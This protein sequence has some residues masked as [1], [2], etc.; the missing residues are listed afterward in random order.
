MLAIKKQKNVIISLSVIFCIIILVVGIILP[1][2]PFK[3]Q[4]YKNYGRMIKSEKVDIPIPNQS[5]IQVLKYY[6]EP[7]W[8]DFSGTIRIPIY[9]ALDTDYMHNLTQ[10][11]MDSKW[12][13]T[14]PLSEDE[15]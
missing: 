5:I 4:H 1:I 11:A 10:K 8:I 14:H 7:F 13:E 9:L 12:L 15:P 2:I 3:P 6:G